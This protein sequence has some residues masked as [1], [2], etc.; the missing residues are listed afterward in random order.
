[1]D[2]ARYLADMPEVWGTLLRRHVADRTG[3]CRECRPSAWPCTLH[4]LATE[5]RR[6]ATARDSTDRSFDGLA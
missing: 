2:A 1:M 5:A 4:A 3:R 6:L